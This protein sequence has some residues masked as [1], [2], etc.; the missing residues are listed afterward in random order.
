MPLLER[1]VGNLFFFVGL[2]A[3]VF[4]FVRLILRDKTEVERLKAKKELL[5]AE[6]KMQDA[7]ARTLAEEN[8]KYDHIIAESEKG[9]ESKEPGSEGG[10]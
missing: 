5:E 10:P 2:P 8:R 9:Q 4:F 7:R 3:V 1:I 6:V